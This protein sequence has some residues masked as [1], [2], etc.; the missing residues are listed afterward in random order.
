MV[1]GNVVPAHH[2]LP[3]TPLSAEAPPR[4]WRR[5]TSCGPGGSGSRCAWTAVGSRDPVPLTRSACRPQ[6][7]RSRA[8][9]AA[10][11]PPLGSAS[12]A[13]P[14]NWSTTSAT[15]GPGDEASRSGP[16]T[17]RPAARLGD[18]VNGAGAAGRGLGRLPGAGGLGTVGNVAA[19]SLT[20]L[21]ALGR[22]RDT[23]LLDRTRAAPTTSIWWW[24]LRV[25]N[26]V[27]GDRGPRP[28]AHGTDQVPGS[29]RGARRAVR[30]GPGR[31]RATRRGPAGGG[32]GAG[33]RPWPAAGCR[34]VASTG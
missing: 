25:R 29:A 4:C 30:R 5:R 8:R 16:G 6:A 15:L 13:S 27:A 24:V 34:Q 19:G 32:R 2:G 26:P 11:R 14:G 22:G 1:F 33:G 23:D 20:R 17:R 28:G 21:L 3:L 18:G 9:A 10:G 12:T 7:G 31:L